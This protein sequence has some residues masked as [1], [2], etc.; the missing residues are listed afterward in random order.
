MLLFKQISVCAGIQCPAGTEP[1]EA[2]CITRRGYIAV[3]LCIFIV[4]GMYIP[5]S[6]LKGRGA[7]VYVQKLFRFLEGFKGQRIIL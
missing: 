1:S 4:R 3:N 7:L 5:D 6:F 2:L